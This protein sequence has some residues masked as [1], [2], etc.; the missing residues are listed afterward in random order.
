MSFQQTVEAHHTLTY[1]QNAMMVAQQLQN[2]LRQAV[3]IQS[4]LTGEARRVSDLLNKKKAQRGSDY[5]RNNPDTRSK[6]DSRWL[7]RPEVIHDGEL[8]DTID[9]WDM[10]LDPTS[11]LVQ[12]SIAAVER[13]VFDIILGIE[14]KSADV[15]TVSGSG[16]LGLATSGKRPS[17]S[18]PLPSGN[19]VAHGGTGLTIEKLRATRKALKKAD[20]G[21]ED[22]DP[23]WACITP[24]QEDDLLAIAQQAGP[25]LNAFNIEQLRTG[26]PTPLLGINWILTNRLPTSAANVRMIP[27]WS[28]SNV[29]AG[30]WQD[31]EGRIWNDT[32]KQN[33]PYIYTSAFVDAVRIQDGGVRVIECQFS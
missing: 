12:N 26:K 24:D 31:V 10:A 9:K 20:F 4:G 22:N 3:T 16:I 32:S 33:L 30:F 25:S 6:W 11:S 5:G 23:L 15:F 7:V 27:V 29:V 2:P 13:E 19:V 8:I 17:T 28:K 14:E 21:I 1:A 18:S